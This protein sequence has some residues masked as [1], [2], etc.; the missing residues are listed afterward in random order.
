MFF[1]KELKKETDSLKTELSAK[2]AQIPSVNCENQLANYKKTLSS[3]ADI[4]L[5]KSAADKVKL[6]INEPID[7]IT[8]DKKNNM[9]INV[10]SAAENK[11]QLDNPVKQNDSV[12]TT[13]GVAKI[14]PLVV[15]PWASYFWYFTIAL[16]CF[17]LLFILFCFFFCCLLSD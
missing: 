11:Q 10:N 7:S 15:N 2:S 5:D 6:L 1:V 16:F 9:S 13:V 14:T 4:Q 8:G 12:L 3:L 17:V